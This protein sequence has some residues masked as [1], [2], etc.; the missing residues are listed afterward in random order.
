MSDQ[1]DA[2]EVKRKLLRQVVCPRC[3]KDVPG[4]KIILTNCMECWREVQ[5][6]AVIR[7]GGTIINE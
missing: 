6:K 7:N 2:A 1:E 3:K 5:R 4:D